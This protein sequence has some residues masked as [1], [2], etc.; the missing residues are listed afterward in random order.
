[1]TRRDDSKA[2]TRELILKTA[3]L[4]FWEKGVEKCTIRKIAKEAG[5]SPA[6]VIVHFKNKTALLEATLNEEIETNIAKTLPNL[7]TDQDLSGM[8]RY[9]VSRMLAVYDKNRDLYRILIRDTY[10]E[11]RHGS[12]SIA[13]LDEKY[14]QF[15][16]EMIEREKGKGYFRKDLDSNL[17]AS[18]ILYLYMG[19]LRKFLIDPEFSVADAESTIA[20]MFQQLIS[21]FLSHGEK[22]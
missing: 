2:E 17:A 8:F 5:V 6:S 3:R 10:Y 21:G 7:P 4:L 12:S 11:T 13:R 19:V 18:S 9:I 14:I 15:I 1:M 22:Q 20:V 16:M